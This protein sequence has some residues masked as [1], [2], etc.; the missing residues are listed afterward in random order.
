MSTRV[1]V[2]DIIVCLRP[3]EHLGAT[4]HSGEHYRVLGIAPKVRVIPGT[5]PDFLYC[6]H[7]NDPSIRVAFNLGD[8]R[9]VRRHSNTP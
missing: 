5:G 6:E 8:V 7:I 3:S 4:G 9:H 2:G 1:H